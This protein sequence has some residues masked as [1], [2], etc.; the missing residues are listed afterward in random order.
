[1]RISSWVLPTRGTE[2]PP[3]SC[4]PFMWG[5]SHLEHQGNKSWGFLEL[6][7][8]L[9]RRFCAGLLTNVCLTNVCLCGRVGLR[10]A[11]ILTQC[12]VGDS[13]YSPGH[14]SRAT[15]ATPKPW[16]SL[17]PTASQ[18]T[19]EEKNWASKVDVTQRVRGKA[20][21]PN[22]S[23]LTLGTDLFTLSSPLQRALFTWPKWGLTT[24]KCSKLA[25]KLQA[26]TLRMALE[27]GH[28]KWII[29]K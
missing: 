28:S 29:P 3:A 5:D 9:R 26:Y 18:Q 12:E 2:S 25:Q 13:N 23:C 16:F 6:T 17:G 11:F 1:M 14:P 4:E 22:C 15:L 27:K 10:L 21:I 7:D 19:A 24:L 8:S 20:R